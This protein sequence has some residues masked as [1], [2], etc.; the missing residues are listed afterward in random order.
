MKWVFLL[1]S[2]VAVYLVLLLKRDLKNLNQI[3]SLSFD[4]LHLSNLL[5]VQ[6]T[7]LLIFRGQEGTFHLLLMKMVI[8][9]L[10]Q[11]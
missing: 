5:E 4:D 2:V 11:N 3:F 9:I 7:N 10:L 1:A 8:K 6:L